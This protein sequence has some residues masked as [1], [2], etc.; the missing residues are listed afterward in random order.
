MGRLPILL[1]GLARQPN[2]ADRSDAHGLECGGRH[3]SGQETVDAGANI[4]VTMPGL[5]TLCH[6]PQL[7]LARKVPGSTFLQAG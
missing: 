2:D 7:K 6:R 4:Y 3:K 5:G 1:S